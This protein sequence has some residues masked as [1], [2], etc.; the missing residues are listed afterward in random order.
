MMLAIS[1][2]D[3]PASGGRLRK[4]VFQFLLLAL[5]GALR[6]FLPVA[7]QC[8]EPFDP[9]PLA[10]LLE[11]VIE[12]DRE[13]AA[14][15]LNKL[16]EKT[17]QGQVAQPR[18]AALREQLGPTL[19]PLVA[20]SRDALWFPAVLVAASWG[21]PAALDHAAAAVS[22]G[23][24]AL[25]D[26]EAG[27]RALVVAK[28]PKV[29]ALAGQLL[30]DRD[31]PE[32]LRNEVL[33]ASARLD[34][35]RLASLVLRSYP[36]LPAETRPRAIE[37]LSQRAVWSRM[38]LEAIQ[39]REIPPTALN[40]NQVRKL[41]S[42]PDP[43]LAEL[44]K[45]SWGTVRDERNPDRERVIDQM[46]TLLTQGE[47]QGNAASGAKIFQRVCGQC[48]K[49]YGQGQEVGP[50]ITRNGRSSFE[51]LLSNVF[52]PSLVIGA[53]YQA[54]TAVT[55]DGRVIT[56]L[57]LEDSPQRL[58]L[59]TQ[60]GKAVAIPRDQIEQVRVSR[61]S[62]MPEGLERQLSRQELLDLFAFLTLDKPPSDPSA[63]RLPRK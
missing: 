9:K 47:G 1:R 59:N 31:A 2:R 26:R 37:L 10:T 21:D 7:A 49:I 27:F 6:A 25:P 8:Q 52:D 4:E 57:V 35:P 22:D 16:A 3:S 32:A 14:N 61:L 42:H 54:Q 50:D 55:S 20:D 30:G 48:H 51:Q 39:R 38:L 41:L 11:L 53:A 43:Q 15:C 29:L 17:T 40:A 24:R 46:R 28:H 5:P 63:K 56:G 23:Q 18:L 45:R 44:V 12:A 33:A 34:D 19:A 36:Q 60:G 58:L 62:L 13:T